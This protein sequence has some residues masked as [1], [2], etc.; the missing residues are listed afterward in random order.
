MIRRNQL[1]AELGALAHEHL[2]ESAWDT[3][4]FAEDLLAILYPHL[5]LERAGAWDAGYNAGKNDQRKG[6]T[7]RTV[8]PHQTG[9]ENA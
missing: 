8:N 6:Q 3:Q 1:A 2:E 7:F 5:Q 4:G 9:K